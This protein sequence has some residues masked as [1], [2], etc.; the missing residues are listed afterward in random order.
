LKKILKKPWNGVKRS[1]RGSSQKTNRRNSLKELGSDPACR[2]F[3]ERVRSSISRRRPCT[4]TQ[5]YK[6]GVVNNPNLLNLVVEWTKV[7]QQVGLSTLILCEEIEQGKAIDEALWSATGGQF[8]PHMFIHGSEST[9]VRTKALQDFGERRL[10]VLVSSTIL[11]EGVD[12]PT[13]D[14]LIL[15]GSRKSRI[16]TMQRLGRGLRGD[17]LIAVEFANFTH[18]YLLRH[19]LQRY[20][21]YK[22]EGCFPVHD[23]GPNL[24]LVKKLWEKD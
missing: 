9:D 17:K 18:D 2:R 4:W 14:A 13:V 20:N 15:A 23:S 12:V 22:A 19:S 5:A 3:E 11:D 6:K 10:P 7:F 8:I 21:D 1:L 24:E 16:K